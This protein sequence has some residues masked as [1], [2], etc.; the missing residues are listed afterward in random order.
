MHSGH[1]RGSAHSMPKP[2]AQHSSALTRP[3]NAMRS[4]RLAKRKTTNS[5]STTARR[6]PTPTC[7]CAWP[8]SSSWPSSPNQK[9]TNAPQASWHGTKPTPKMN[10][11][12]LRSVP[13]GPT[14]P[15]SSATNAAR[16][17]WPTRHS[18]KPRAT[19]PPIG[20]CAPTVPR[21][22][23]SNTQSKPARLM[24]IAASRR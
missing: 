18:K 4:E 13:P 22:P 24:C 23:T 9:H 2:S 19:F 1:W 3:S 7:T 15:T 5:C 11:S 6:S 21:A 17:S 12:N 14:K 8:R 10:G 16:I 20:R